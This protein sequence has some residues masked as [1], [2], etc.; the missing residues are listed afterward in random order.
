VASFFKYLTIGTM[1]ALIIHIALDMYGRTK[2][3]RGEL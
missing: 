2:R 3:L 1:L